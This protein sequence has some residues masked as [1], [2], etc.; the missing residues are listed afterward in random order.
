MTRRRLDGE[1]VRRHLVE[2]RAAAQR[3]IAAG[4]VLVDG[5]PAPKPATLVSGDASLRLVESEHP[6][7]GRGGLKLD[8]ALEAFAVDVAGMSCLDAGA[9]T[10]GFTD[11]L[12][13]RGA[14]HVVAVDVGYGQLAWS[15]R[16]DPRVKVVERTNVRLAD[17]E[18][19]G[20][21]FD[22]VVADLSF[23]SLRLVAEQLSIAAGRGPLILL[24]KPQFEVGKERVGKGGIVTEASDHRDAIIGVV[25]AYRSLGRHLAG[26]IES[27]ITGAKGNREFLVHLASDGPDVGLDAI[28]AAVG[29]E[30]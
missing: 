22:I 25:E 12:L 24:V 9:S 2:S 19:L 13:Q 11:C 20:A 26:V 15:L 14:S 28:E 6:F 3:A 1:L 27:P 23:I 16:S 5:I 18:T 4:R 30:S 8:A 10:G 17:L 21:P 29:G 7:V